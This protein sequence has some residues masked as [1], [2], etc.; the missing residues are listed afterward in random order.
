MSLLSSLSF[1]C[2][3]PVRDDFAIQELPIAVPEKHWSPTDRSFELLRRHSQL[4]SWRIL[5]MATIKRFEDLL[6]WQKAR[7]ITKS[8]YSL[9]NRTEFARDFGLKDQIRRSSVSI[10][11]NLAEGF[12]RRTDRDFSYFLNVSR[13]SAAEVQSHLYIAL[14]QGYV[15]SDTFE[16]LYAELDEISRMIF[17]LVRHLNR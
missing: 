3:I 2:T 9:T 17:G 5:T 15:D 1:F 8:I 11:A 16:T 10:M 6:A 4:Q 13:S 7:K 14:D 12:A